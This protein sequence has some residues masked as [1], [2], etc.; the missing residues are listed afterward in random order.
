MKNMKIPQLLCLLFVFSGC[1]GKISTKQKLQYIAD[2]KEKIYLENPY[3]KMLRHQ[4]NGVTYNALDKRYIDSQYGIT[5]DS[6]FRR[7]GQVD[8]EKTFR[9]ITFSDSDAPN[10]VYNDFITSLN[11]AT[12]WNFKLDGA[13]LEFYERILISAL[14]PCAI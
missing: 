8:S 6:Y 13:F 12:K 10:D 1:A 5:T 2:D 11:S 14:M 9:I 4:I 7:N 3:S